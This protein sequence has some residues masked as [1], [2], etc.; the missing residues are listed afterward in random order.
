MA[1][2]TYSTV[3]ENFLRY[4][5]IDTQS[6][7]RYADRTPSTE[8]QR[9]LACLLRDELLKLGA[10]N[11]RYDEAHCYV[12]AE[13]PSNVSR[14]KQIPKI[15]FIAHIDTSEAVSGENVRPR[16]IEDYDGEDIVLNE[17]DN[18][19]TRVSEF[20]ILQACKGKSLIVTDGNTLLGGDDKAGVAEIMAMAEYF[21][22]HPE[23]EHGK[24]CIGF[25]PDEEVGNGV[26]FFDIEGFDA[27][28]AYTVDGGELGDM[29]YECFNAAGATLT[30]RGKSVHP[31]S[32]KNIM[33]NAVKLAYEFISALPNECPENTEGYE[34]F[35]HVDSI[36][37][38]V[39]K[40][41]VELII[42]D[43]D[44]EKFEQRK[45]IV[46]DNV[47][48]LN[49]K[50]GEKTFTLEMKEQ[51]RNM[52]EMIEKEMSIVDNAVRAMRRA[53][54]EP[55]ISPIRG[56][57]DGARLSFDGLLCPNICT[58]SE[59]HHGRNEFACIEDMETIVE[60]LKY[61]VLL[62]CDA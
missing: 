24:I 36:R 6:L 31:G 55:K 40:T 22:K 60:I 35:Y 39:E 34:G 32:A 59:G 5:K 8:K 9:D 29:S 43:H 13:I 48:M 27:D 2:K 33:K 58:G 3:V 57:T 52:R 41:I 10:S 20:P 51:Y 11:V 23:V 7:E 47:E 4:V 56:G 21:L 61:I 14:E 50:Y 49:A 16:I 62:P 53:G 37:G 38:D 15:G 54:V 42:R 30:V 18:I 28:Y 46:R 45:Q 26:A 17:E 44:S 1:E 25:T 19:V 12:Y